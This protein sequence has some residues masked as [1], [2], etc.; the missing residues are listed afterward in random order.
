MSFHMFYFS[1]LVCSGQATVIFLAQKQ[2]LLL[3]I[4]A[5]FGVPTG[6]PPAVGGATGAMNS[7]VLTN[8]GDSSI[9][10]WSWVL[11]DYYFEG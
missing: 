7:V 4:W 6:G 11:L 2:N 8:D 10:G 1:G 5:C 9:L 3:F